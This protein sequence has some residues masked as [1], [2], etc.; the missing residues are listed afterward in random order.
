MIKNPY[1]VHFFM[2]NK[3][4]IRRRIERDK[5]RRA[6]KKATALAKADNYDTATDFEAIWNAG[7][8]CCN[9]VRWKASVQRWELFLLTGAYDVY[10]AAQTGR[11]L[12]ESGDFY[13]FDLFERGHLRHIRSLKIDERTAQRS[14]CDN[15]LV[16]ALER[17][18]IYDNGATMKGKGITFAEERL[19]K[20]LRRYAREYGVEYVLTN[21]YVVVFDFHH[22]FDNASH[23]TL[24][25]IVKKVLKDKRLIEMIEKFV[26]DFGEVGL[27]LGSQISQI[28]ALALADR[29]DHELKDVQRLKF[30]GR[31]MD[32]GYILCKDK[33][34]AIAVLAVIRAVCEELEIVVN[35]KKTRIVKFSRGFKFLKITYRMTPT[36]RIVRKTNHDGIKRER[37]RLRAFKRK[38]DAGN[39]E[40]ESIEASV[41]AWL[42]HAK[43]AD[44]GKTR[45]NM[46]IRFHRMFPDSTAFYPPE[47]IDKTEVIVAAAFAADWWKHHTRRG[48]WSKQ[49][50]IAAYK[51]Q[52]EERLCRSFTS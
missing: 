30:Y 27:G 31:Y 12:K 48:W 45:L 16:P 38:Y 9:G 21:G 35:E 26:A 43:R 39:M 46:I 40:L 28:L 19:T 52:K 17:S 34:Q 37:Q 13:C 6:A 18:F 51:K 7:L 11:L 24:E 25:R 10:D 22:Y 29:L 32:D 5:A 4:R 33:A 8:K 36:G 20:H 49:H 47:P 3:E 42:A 15:S 44:S 1:W 23:K 2:N 50:M 14:L 41:Q